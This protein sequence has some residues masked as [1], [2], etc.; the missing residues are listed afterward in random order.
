[1]ADQRDQALA[2][3]VERFNAGE[4]S[5]RELLRR[6]ADLDGAAVVA[7]SVGMAAPGAAKAAQGGSRRVRKLSL[8][9]QP[10]AN[11][12]EEFESIQLAA[13]QLREI[14]LD[15]DIQVMPWEQMSDLVWFNRDKW[16]MTAWQMVGRPERLDPD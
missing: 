14:G 2:Q 12:P 8:A 5:R 15:L 11:V 10:Q 13:G 7:G 16:D 6:T 4:L 1:M 3:L 9:V